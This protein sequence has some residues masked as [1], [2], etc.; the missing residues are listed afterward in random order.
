MK[1]Q[2]IKQV[3]A[4]GVGA[5]LFVVIGMIN[6]PTPVPNTSI[7]LQ[8]AVQSLLSIIFG[9]LVGL[10]VG[11]IGHAVKDAIAGYGLWWTWIIASG[12]F[13]LAVGLFRK[14]IRVTQGVFELKD[15]VF[16]NLIQI[17]ANALVWGVLAPLG[18]VVIYQEAA[19]KVFAQGIVAG[20]ANA[21]TIAIAGTL[22]L[23]A[24]SR[25]QTRSG[26]LKKD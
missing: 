20:I 10:L 1:N 23:L 3:V 9:P 16:F 5:A 2:S 17:V 26:S 18:D 4:I 11:L 13:G 12:L 19:E 24:Y 7:Q 15:I 22:L 25:T 8:Y 6:I 21:V 14:Y